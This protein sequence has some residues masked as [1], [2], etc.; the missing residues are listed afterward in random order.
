MHGL[1]WQHGSP[2]RRLVVGVVDYC[3]T[4]LVCFGLVEW[5]FPSISLNS[6]IVVG[7]IVLAGNVSLRE[8][9]VAAPMVDVTGLCGLLCFLV[10]TAEVA[11]PGIASN[12]L[13]AGA[14]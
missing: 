11:L 9:G 5:W 6:F 2:G 12:A 14:V 13:A 1:G 4:G 7:I 10:G 8:E 3:G